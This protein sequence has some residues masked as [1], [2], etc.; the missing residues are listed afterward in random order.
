MKN[1]LVISCIIFC[2][3]LCSCSGADDK[4]LESEDGKVNLSFGPILQ[5]LMNSQQRQANSCI[6]AVPSVAELVVSQKGQMVAGTHRDPL[7]I[8]FLQDE[9]GAY[10]TEESAE[11]SLEPGIGVLEYFRILDKH[12]NPIWLSPQ[13][14]A[15][16][17]SEFV[18]NPLPLE[19][20]LDVSGPQY[21]GVEVICVDQNLEDSYGYSFSTSDAVQGIEFCIFGN[22]CDENGRHAEAIQYEVSAWTF[23]GDPEDPQGTVIYNRELSPLII[24]DNEDG[25]SSSAA[26]PLCLQLPDTEGEDQYY[27][28]IYYAGS[29]I[30]SGTIMDS[31]VKNLYEGED[32]MDYFHFREGNCNLPD[33]PDLF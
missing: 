15:N 33:S 26:E 23:T 12:G 4:V 3:I 10:Y 5:N 21:V 1:K 16:G 8:K 9:N 17:V 24:T 31:E 18:K 6:G 14:D 20:Q 11:L 29:L 32:R 30:R 19:I 27:L 7:R 13:G 2:S 28:E 25:S 22:Y